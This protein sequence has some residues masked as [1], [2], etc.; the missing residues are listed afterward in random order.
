[1]EFLANFMWFYFNTIYDGIHLYTRVYSKNEINF[2]M[3]IS[4]YSNIRVYSSKMWQLYHP[5]IYRI[6]KK[7]I[8]K[9]I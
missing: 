3:Y 1:M 6:S 5:T 8:F 4:V 9:F 2:H 7:L